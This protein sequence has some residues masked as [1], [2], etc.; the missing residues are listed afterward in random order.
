M[1]KLSGGF[2]L[3]IT[4]NNQIITMKNLTPIKRGENGRAFKIATHYMHDKDIKDGH[5][6]TLFVVDHGPWNESE[7]TL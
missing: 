5:R 3:E 7:A 2:I 4:S 1:V 6:Y